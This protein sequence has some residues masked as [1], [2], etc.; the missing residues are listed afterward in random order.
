MLKVAHEMRL[1]RYQR[2]IEK[3]A[4]Q[5]PTAWHLVCLAENKC[6]FEHF[7]R[8]KSRIEFDISLGRAAPPMWDAGSPWSAI[9][10]KAAEDDET[11]WDDN[12]RHPA[13][14]WLAHGGR[15]SQSSRATGCGGGACRR[16]GGA[17][18]RNVSSSV[19]SWG[20]GTS[21]KDTVRRIKRERS[22]APVADVKREAGPPL[23]KKPKG[24][25]DGKGGK[26]K[27]AHHTVDQAGVQLCFSWNFGV[28]SFH[29]EAHVQL[30]EFKNAPRVG[31]TSTR[32]GSAHRLDWIERWKEL[33]LRRRLF[34]P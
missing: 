26:N 30:A 31:R 8:S 12:I 11:Y 27:G 3:L 22:A 20:Q 28:A 14:S 2:K 33:G 23:A 15:R 32:R 5:W 10:L 29:Q 16:C 9:F 7:N 21:T 19:N 17:R 1:D 18:P 13:M 34:H 4:T 24:K 6:R 25:S